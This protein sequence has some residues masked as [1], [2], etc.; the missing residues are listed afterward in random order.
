MLRDH[1]TAPRRHYS[2]M[3]AEAYCKRHELVSELT[4]AQLNGV[5]EIAGVDER[6]RVRV[7]IAIDKIA[8]IA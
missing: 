2:L 1:K 3:T 7:A 6:G 8:E 4:V 5:V